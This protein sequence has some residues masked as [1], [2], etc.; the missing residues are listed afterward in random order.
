[1]E[2]ELAELP[3]Q[4]LAHQTELLRQHRLDAKIRRALGRVLRRRRVKS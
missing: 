2:E 3:D 4:I 1:L